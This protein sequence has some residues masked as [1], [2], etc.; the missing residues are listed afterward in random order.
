MINENE[1]RLQIAKKD[2]TWTSSISQYG[3]AIWVDI[4]VPSGFEFSIQITPFDGIGVTRRK[5]TDTEVDLGG[6]D[7]VFAT[8]SEALAYIG[9]ITPNK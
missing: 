6:H 1:I 5:K 7:E 4:S 2:P 9:D 8:F 3:I